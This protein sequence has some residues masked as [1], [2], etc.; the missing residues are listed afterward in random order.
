MAD[1]ERCRATAAR[2]ARLASLSE[3]AEARRSY[4]ELERLWLEIAVWAEKLNLEGGSAR[5]AASMRL[6]SKRAKSRRRRRG[7]TE[8]SVARRPG[9]L[10]SL[11]S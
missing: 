7:C 9:G 6:S 3:D 2:Y 5:G 11:A 4:W 1:S 10:R 8:G